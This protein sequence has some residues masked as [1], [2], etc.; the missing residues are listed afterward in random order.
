MVSRVRDRYSEAK[1][2]LKPSG[3]GEKEFGEEQRVERGEPEAEG[4]K[5]NPLEEGETRSC[6]EGEVSRSKSRPGDEGDRENHI[7]G[8]H[9]VTLSSM[10]TQEGISVTSRQD[11]PKIGEEPEVDLVTADARAEAS[12]SVASATESSY[13]N[14]SSGPTNQDAAEALEVPV[15]EDVDGEVTD[16]PAV[17]VAAEFDLRNI[18]PASLTLDGV[19]RASE[20]PECARLSPFGSATDDC[21]AVG[22]SL[23][24]DLQDTSTTGTEAPYTGDRET[25]ESQFLTADLQK[26]SSGGTDA[27]FAAESG[28]TEDRLGSD[29]DVTLEATPSNTSTGLNGDQ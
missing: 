6:A 4:A 20:A 19:E 2:G 16:V 15:G 18:D 11:P 9:S 5:S 10:V 24:A 13:R 17:V 26:A 29:D 1:A 25:R 8:R 23:P 22:Q 28:A 7:P 27:P 12:V 21:G 14:I 3:M